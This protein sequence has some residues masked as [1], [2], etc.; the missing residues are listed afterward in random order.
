[1]L[2]MPM[3]RSLRRCSALSTG[4]NFWFASMVETS[5]SCGTRRNSGSKPHRIARGHSTRQDTSSTSA[6]DTRA[7]PSAL[8]A[9]AS[10]SLRT[11]ASRSTGSTSTCAQRSAST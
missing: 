9:A 1:M 10:I 2:A 4:K 3:K 7:L 8:A 6:C 5:A 11:F